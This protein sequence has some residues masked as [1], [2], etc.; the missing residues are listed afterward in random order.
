MCRIRAI[1]KLILKAQ[2]PKFGDRLVGEWMRLFPVQVYY[3]LHFSGIYTHLYLLLSGTGGTLSGVGQYLKSVN[4][5]IV[6]ILSDP[7]GSGLYNKVKI[8]ALF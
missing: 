7:E 8:P 2:D 5:D 6:V 4:E 1:T 3:M